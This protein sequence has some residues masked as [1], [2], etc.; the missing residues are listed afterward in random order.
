[1]LFKEEQ[2]VRQSKMGVITMS[3]LSVI[4][5]VAILIVLFASE[6]TKDGIIVAV[7]SLFF[8]APIIGIF[9]AGGNDRHGVVDQGK[10]CQ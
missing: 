9:A 1:M 10:G 3:M 2:Y 8:I 4:S 6:S 5:L 7:A